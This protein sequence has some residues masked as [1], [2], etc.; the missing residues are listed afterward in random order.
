MSNKHHTPSTLQHLCSF[1]FHSS[2]APYACLPIATV[3][4]APQLLTVRLAC[5]R[6]HKH[7]ELHPGLDNG[8]QRQ[9]STLAATLVKT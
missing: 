3:R 5:T 2:Q 4:V 6:P 1:C 9:V 8:T 7:R